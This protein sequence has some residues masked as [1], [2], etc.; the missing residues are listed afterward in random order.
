MQPRSRDGTDEAVDLVAAA[1]QQQQRDALR[2]E[3]RGDLG[4]SVDVEFDDLEAPG[5]IV[6]GLVDKRR[7]HATRSAPGRPEVDQHGQRGVDRAVERGCVRVDD[8]GQR[9]VAEATAR[10]PRGADR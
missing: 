9:R 6:R 7:E 3:A 1:Q 4:S 2:A 8:P 10:C 5:V